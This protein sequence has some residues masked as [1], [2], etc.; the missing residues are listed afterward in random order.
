MTKTCPF[1]AGDLVVYRPSLKGFGLEAMATERLVPGQTYRV[2]EIQ[3][4]MYL[5]PEGYSHPGGGIIWTE[6]SAS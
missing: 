2:K 6:F 4:D 1:K 3:K 5:L